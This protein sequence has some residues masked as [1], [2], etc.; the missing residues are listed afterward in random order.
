MADEPGIVQFPIWLINTMVGAIMV[1]I[2]SIGGYMVSWNSED[3]KHKAMV[4]TKLDDIEDD[5]RQ[6]LDKLDEHLA[7]G[8]HP[9]MEIRMDNMEDWVDNHERRRDE[10]LRELDKR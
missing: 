3:G 6:I 8:G 1:S 10:R 5:Q 7:R 2:I 9:Q 4:I